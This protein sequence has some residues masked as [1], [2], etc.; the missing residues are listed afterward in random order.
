MGLSANRGVH[1]S[2]LL[3]HLASDV[4]SLFRSKGGPNHADRVVPL[5]FSLLLAGT[6]LLRARPCPLDLRAL[7]PSVLP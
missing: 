7:T 2:H 3:P 6:W 4:D 1:R 5:L